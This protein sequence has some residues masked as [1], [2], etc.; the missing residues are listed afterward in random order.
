MSNNAKKHGICQSVDVTCSVR[1]SIIDTGGFKNIDQERKSPIDVHR[2]VAV[3]AH[4]INAI[5]GGE[6]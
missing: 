5:F 1:G 4:A 2:A 6:Q 3:P